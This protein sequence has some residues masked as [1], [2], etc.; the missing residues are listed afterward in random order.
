MKKIIFVFFLVFILT[1][2]KSQNNV[3]IGL[4]T[5][6]PRSILE[7]SAT[8]KGFLVPRLTTFQRLN[9]IDTSATSFPSS[10]RALLVY[11]ID[12]RNFWYV[13]SVPGLL[14]YRWI[15]AIGPVGPTGPTGPTG[16]AGATGLIGAIGPT[17]VNGNTGAAGV[18]GATGPAG[19]NGV[20]GTAGVN[21]VTGAAGVNGATGAAGVNGVTGPAGVAGVTGAAGDTGPTG[22]AGVTGPTGAASSVPGPTGATGPTGFGIGPTGPTGDPGPTG[23]AGS[24]GATGPTGAAGTSGATG[25]TGVAGTAGATG[26]TGA[27]GAAGATGQTGAAGAAGTTGPTGAAG[28]TGASGSTGPTW[29]LTQPTFNASGTLTVNGTAGSGGPQTT[30]LQAWLVGGNTL[31]ATGIFGTLS[32]NHIDYYTNGLVRGR[33]SNLGEFF[34]GTTATAMA[35]DLMNGVANATFDWAVNGYTAFDGGGVYGSVTAGTTLFGGVQGEYLGSSATG[36]G[37]RG[38]DNLDNAYGV[39]GQS[40]VIGWAG[41]FDGDLNYT[42][43]L[44]NISDSKLKI[45][46]KDLSDPIDKIMKIHPIEYDFDTASYKGYTLPTRHQYG[47]LAQDIEENFPELVKAGKLNPFYTR[48][49]KD[50]LE[51]IDIK[52]VNYVEMIPITIGAIQ[53]QQRIIRKKYSD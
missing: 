9:N 2:L 8:D 5:P 21:G 47:V 26:P 20:T 23:A 34:I 50:N 38:I 36:A 49:R 45:N 12:T 40:G 11:D 25:P 42:G 35:G 27:A 43:G 17:G 10:I 53:E 46:V 41:W 44:Y 4:T 31:A 32:N 28:T 33:I 6:E 30:A 3:G 16:P 51:P 29:T 22:A 37:V 14:G 19:V 24:A 7:L 1:E 52:T 13:D 15:K 48:N 18:N 39:N